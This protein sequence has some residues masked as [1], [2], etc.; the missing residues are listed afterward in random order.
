MRNSFLA[1]V[2]AA[3]LTVAPF[4]AVNAAPILSNP[5]NADG[6]RTTGYGVDLESD[7]LG[8][9]DASTDRLRMSSRQETYYRGGGSGP[10]FT[11]DSYFE[12]SASVDKLGRVIDRGS[13]R[14]EGD[15]GSG[16]ELLAT[17]N[18]IDLGFADTEHRADASVDDPNHFW[19]MRLLLRVDYLDARFQEMGNHFGFYYEQLWKTAHTSPFMQ[20]WVCLPNTNIGL[21]CVGPESASGIGGVIL[22]VPEPGTLALLTLALVGILPWQRAKRRGRLMES[23]V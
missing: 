20:D 8:I 2:A 5:L 11:F 19:L 17:G 14:W 15:F 7:V 10:L 22:D 18:L 16:R 21:R 3:L 12:L 4:V 9:Y 6:V 23:R 13:M 1:A